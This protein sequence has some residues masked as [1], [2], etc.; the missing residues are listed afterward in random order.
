MRR[1]RDDHA[2]VLMFLGTDEFQFKAEEWV[3][4]EEVKSDEVKSEEVKSDGAKEVKKEDSK[5]KKD[6]K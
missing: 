4:E 6:G 2:G 1:Y 3:E 5:P